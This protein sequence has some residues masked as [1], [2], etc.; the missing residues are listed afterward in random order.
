MFVWPPSN[1]VVCIL[2]KC[3]LAVINGFFW[4]PLC[5][6]T[7]VL[8]CA[9]GISHILARKTSKRATCDPLFNWIM[10]EQWFDANEDIQADQFGQFARPRM[11]YV[12]F[13]TC[14][15]SLL[16]FPADKLVE[17]VYWGCVINRAYFFFLGD[18]LLWRSL[19]SNWLTVI[20]LLCTKRCR[21]RVTIEGQC[22]LLLISL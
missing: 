10:L 20:V 2:W 17:L 22:V 21:A 7:Y 19:L 9:L 13:V 16:F 6:L 4:V 3:S 5:A 18:S 14:H 12:S 15:K 11:C 8:A 1:N